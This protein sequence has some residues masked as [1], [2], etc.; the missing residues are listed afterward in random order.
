MSWSLIL[1]VVY[2]LLLGFILCYSIAQLFILI[3][4]LRQRKSIY[5]ANATQLQ[6]VSTAT[7]WPMVTVQLPVYNESLVVERLLEAVSHLDY[8]LNKLQ[9]QVLDD[10]T[11]E[12]ADIAQRKVE[13]LKGLKGLDIEWIHRTDRSGFKAGA[14]HLGLNS[15]KGEYIAIFD[16]DFVP[17]P[18]FL[19]ATVP[20]FEDVKIGVVQSRWE[21]LNRD[22]SWLTELQ[23]LGLDAHFSIEQLGRNAAG[24]F[25]NFNGT[26][27]VWRKSTIIDAGGWQSDT[28][29]EDLDLSYRAQLKGWKFKFLEEVTSPAELPA[30][31]N[32]IKTQQF[33][34]T[35]GAAECA[36]KNLG[37]VLR[38]DTVS[39]STKWHALFH[40]MNSFMFVCIVISGLISVPLV[41]AKQLD[42]QY[43]WLFRFGGIFLFSLITLSATYF[44]SFSNRYEK[45]SQAILPFLLKYPFFLSLYMGLSLHNAIAVIEGYVGKKSPFI[46]TPKLNVK[47]RKDS[48]HGNQY[49]TSVIN[50]L[51]L[52]EL[53][54]MGYFILG[55]ILDIQYQDYG[56]LP[57]HVLLALGFG[58]VAGYSIKHSLAL[59]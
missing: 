6:S 11:D 18:N 17:D 48:W 54:F 31:M 7:N 57:F 26:A 49:L 55:I 52:L 25:I 59:K 38:D 53:L 10:S 47:S 33:R 37:K 30:A 15:A 8:P 9:I 29:T 16:A 45:R 42:N 44:V 46:R 32:A 12:S 43:D 3:A 22:Y 40:L 36:R 5:A 28:L 21:H 41:Y 13:S 50:G 14:L 20:F 19:K 56:L 4:Y 39:A 2:G 1:Q 24:H 27:G 58:A 34:W 51:T 35:K 23:A